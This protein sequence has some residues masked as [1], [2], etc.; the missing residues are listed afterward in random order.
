VAQSLRAVR[1]LFGVPAATSS[2]SAVNGPGAASVSG[3][4]GSASQREQAGAVA[5]DERRSTF[6]GADR[7]LDRWA[8]QTA[9]DT[10]QGR[11][12][13]NGLIQSADSSTRALAPYTG[14]VPGRV[15]L[16][17]S[18]TDHLGGA[19]NL[20]S[21]YGI[22]IPQR[23]AE[24]AALAARY[25]LTPPPPGAP[26]PPPRRPP[27]RRR[28]PRGGVPMA[29]G[30]AMPRGGGMSIATGGISVPDFGSAFRPPRGSPPRLSGQPPGEPR[31]LPIGGPATFGDLTPHQMQV[32]KAI[33]AEA[34]RRH[35]PPKAAVIGVATS[36]QESRLRVLANPAVPSS[37]RLPHVG[38]GYNHDSV[39]PFQQRQ[40]W[41]ATPD[42]MNPATSAS[43]FYDKLMRIPNWESLP[44][45]V[46]AQKVQVSAYP[47][48]YAKHEGKA[49]AVVRAILG[50]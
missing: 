38:V 47:S 46:A 11:S 2:S 36:M 16:V 12:S 26:P 15:A 13:A 22:T 29:G 32:A 4:S 8:Q 3:W 21:G 45:T 20:V 10:A 37:M 19:G 27:R 50:G 48:A 34:M 39:G 6:T 14:T 23:Q 41:G 17:S 49:A 5:L 40:S 9:A 35:L 25:G 1:D 42:L 43:K 7:G 24:L 18:L 44:V 31:D 30:L 28:R 33:V